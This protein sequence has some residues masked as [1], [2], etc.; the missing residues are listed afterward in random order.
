MPTAVKTAFDVAYW[1]SDA[2]L[3][4]NQYLQPQKLQRLLYL[5]Q[6][7][8]AV[9]HSGR[10]L[11]PAIFVADETGPIE[12]NIHAA[13]ARGRPSLETDS[14]LPDDAEAVL[15]G[16]WSRFGHLGCDALDRMTASTAAYLEARARGLRAEIDHS[17]MWWSFAGGD[18]MPNADKVVRPTLLRTQSGRPVVVQRWDPGASPVTALGAMGARSVDGQ[19]P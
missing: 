17:A 19:E 9:L 12:P 1:L 3:N 8:Y 11:M 5:A 2:A 18:A 15:N 16:V 7:Y 6:A 13:L 10:K 14:A 4:D